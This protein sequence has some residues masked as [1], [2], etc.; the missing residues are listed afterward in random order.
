VTLMLV[1]PMSRIAIASMPPSLP[2]SGEDGE[3]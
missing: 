3:D 2:R 1:L